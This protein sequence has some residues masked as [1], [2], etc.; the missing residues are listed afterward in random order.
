MDDAVLLE[1]LRRQ[2][3]NSYTQQKKNKGNTPLTIFPPLHAKFCVSHEIICWKLKLFDVM[4]SNLFVLFV[5]IKADSTAAAVDTVLM[6]I[7]V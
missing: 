2:N 4:A 6:N 3:S 1:N 5:I 7:M